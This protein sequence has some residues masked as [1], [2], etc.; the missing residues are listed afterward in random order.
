MLTCQHTQAIAEFGSSPQ[1]QDDDDS[2]WRSTVV[3][4]LLFSLLLLL[5][6][7]LPLNLINVIFLY[8]LLFTNFFPI[9][10]SFFPRSPDDAPLT[11]LLCFPL[12]KIINWNKRNKTHVK[13]RLHPLRSIIF[14]FFFAMDFPYCSLLAAHPVDSSDVKHIRHQRV[15]SADNRMDLQSVWMWIN[16][17]HLQQQS[18]DKI[19]RT[20]NKVFDFVT[21]CGGLSTMYMR[22]GYINA[23]SYMKR[24]LNPGEGC[25]CLCLSDLDLN[26]CKPSFEGLRAL[27][28]FSFEV[29][30]WLIK[31]IE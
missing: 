29:K 14:V 19:N 18:V 8:Y 28:N 20:W 3:A 26:S 9:G 22:S 5:S 11:W 24:D 6:A 27:A 31:S 2:I 23:I 10:L 25:D 4:S 1:P 13:G 7:V 12:K 30:S 21:L 16:T 15:R 17:L